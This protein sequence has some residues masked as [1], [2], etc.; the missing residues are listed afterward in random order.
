MSSI[1][2][3]GF[4]GL[5]PAD[6]AFIDAFRQALLKERQGVI[7]VTP[8]R[9][10]MKEVHPPQLLRACRRLRK[11]VET[12][13]SQLTEHFGVAHIRVRDLWHYQHRL[14]RKILAHTVGIF[15]NL[16]AGQPPL[17]LDRLLSI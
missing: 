1:K 4:T 12:V 10:G 14:I 17:Q 15:L 8:A 16:Q 6:K 13:G 3:E 7:V 2:V 9:K 11:R 5:V